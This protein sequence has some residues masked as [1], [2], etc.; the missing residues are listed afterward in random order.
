VDHQRRDVGYGHRVGQA[1]R[2]GDGFIV[3]RERK[4]FEAKPIKYKL[5]MRASDTAEL[6]ID[7]V[8]I[9]RANRLPAPTA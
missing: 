8:R 3:E 2:S 1:G 4:G 7:E 5:S 9:P 6:V